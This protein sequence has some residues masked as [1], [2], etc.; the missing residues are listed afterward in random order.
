MRIFIDRSDFDSLPPAVVE[1]I[2]RVAPD[3]LTVDK[4]LLKDAHKQELIHWFSMVY[5]ALRFE[6]AE[7]LE[8]SSIL[9]RGVK[10]FVPSSEVKICEWG[11]YSYG[12]FDQ[13][14]CDVVVNELGITIRIS[15][16]KGSFTA[17][18][19]TEIFFQSI[20]S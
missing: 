5:R 4:G 19:M 18:A 6:N 15:S 3:G 8:R 12:I 16:I 20:Q 17:P 10:V 13:D 7:D 1:A 9:A 14:C 2:G 11:T